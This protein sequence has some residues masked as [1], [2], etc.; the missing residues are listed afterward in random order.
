MAAKKDEEKIEFKGITQ[1]ATHRKIT[2]ASDDTI[3]DFSTPSVVPDSTTSAP[4]IP[5][6]EK[7]YQ[8]NALVHKA[9]NLRANRLIGNGFDLRPAE[10]D[11]VDPIIAEQALK[12]CEQF[13][14]DIHYKTF[15]RQSIINAYVSGNEFTEIIRNKLEHVVNVNHGDFRT[16][17]YRR[18][19]INNKILLGSDGE[20]E[21]YWQYIEDLSQLYRSISLLYGSIGS[22]KNLMAAK[23][24]LKES[25][26]LVIEDDKGHTIAMVTTKPNYMFL[27]KDEI[28]HLA[29]NTLN[30]TRRGTSH[31][32]PAYDAVT[33]LNNITFAI[34]EMFNTIG[35]PKPVIT[36]GDADHPP[37]EKMYAQAEET[38]QDPVRKESFILPYFSKLEYLVNPTTGDAAE[39]PEWFITNVA[40]GLRVPRELLTGEGEAN[41][42]TAE[43]GSTDF[44]KDCQADQFVFEEYVYSVLDQFLKS[45]G[46]IET[47]GKRS[48]Y[49][50]QI[51]WHKLIVED[52]VKRQ[53]LALDLFDRNIITKNQTLKILEKPL[54]EDGTG[55][56]YSYQLTTPQPQMPNQSQPLS[57]N[58]IL[59]PTDAMTAQHSLDKKSV[60]NPTLN[61]RYKTEDVDYKGIAQD[62]MVKQVVSVPEVTAKKIRDTIVNGVAANESA[63]SIFDKVQKLGNYTD[64]ETERIVYTEYRNLIEN[65]KFENAKNKGVK[66][67]I[68]RAR[69][70]QD[71]SPICRSLNGK[72]APIDKEFTTLYK[73]KSGK[74]QRWKG[75]V[76]PAHPN[77]RST[78]EYVGDE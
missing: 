20:P 42:A 14:K 46:F 74:V 68:W 40:I 30:D 8:I 26:S 19:F 37:N 78:I 67:K 12:Q 77:C 61:K 71:T 3:Y 11:N 6:L 7:I 29:F 24:R 31:I 76:P 23:N 39:Y 18:D 69:L 59:Q 45:R 21:G 22:Y 66:T 9:I 60:L 65:A 44:D 34:G 58:L 63:K 35:Y 49:C 64:Y 56:K 13:L 10:G 2:L 38:I 41:R 52:E 32:L 47:N 51:S 62:K 75:N 16:I 36:V 17:D 48:L 72:K 54:A 43:Q 33:E 1:K 50:P 25:Q 28:C 15:F 53:Q 55:D 70:D 73:D 5:I 4:T 57:Q 27:R